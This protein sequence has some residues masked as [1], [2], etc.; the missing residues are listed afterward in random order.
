MCRFRALRPF[1]ELTALDKVR[2]PKSYHMRS[3]N[4]QLCK[5]ATTSQE[6]LA[7]EEARKPSFSLQGARRSARPNSIRAL[8]FRR[9]DS[10]RSLRPR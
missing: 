10:H 9:Y 6:S 1:I 4:V 5:R 8:T 3:L 7:E 2:Q